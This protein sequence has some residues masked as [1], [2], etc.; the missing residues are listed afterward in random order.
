MATEEI[1]ML[2]GRRI[3]IVSD[4]RPDSD[5]AMMVKE[6]DRAS[7]RLGFYCS[8]LTPMAYLSMS[9]S[10]N[11]RIARPPYKIAE[12]L[13]HYDAVHIATEG[14]LGLAARRACKK[15]GMPYTTSFSNVPKFLR[16]MGIPKWLSYAYCRWFHK[17]SKSVLVTSVV[18]ARA[19]KAN[20]IDNV[21]V[22]R[23]GVD[24]SVF[25]PREKEVI[26]KVFHFPEDWVAPFWVTVCPLTRNGEVVDF[27]KLDL[28]GTKIVI[29]TGPAR[30]YL[31]KKFKD[32]K[33]MKRMTDREMSYCLNQA[34]VVVIPHKTDPHQSTSANPISCGTP[35]AAYPHARLSESVVEG[36]SGALDDDLAAACLRALAIPRET[37]WSDLS[38]NKSINFFISSLIFVR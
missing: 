1:F 20:G 38:W 11:F 15:A 17:G 13:E 35:V 29:G 9:P 22:W 16:I 28:P 7:G 4:A 2:I 19:A 26:G 18:A 5:D 31:E 33:F 12:M 25:Q 34:N 6:V 8:L 23:S 21:R 3:L 14:P 32:V 30:N 27:C 24:S 10:L 36:V 37:V